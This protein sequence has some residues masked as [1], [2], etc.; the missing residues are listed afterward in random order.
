MADTIDEQIRRAMEDGQFDN[1]PGKGRPINLDENPFEDPEWRMAH[2]L[3]QEGGF[4]LPWIEARREIDS[5]LE[6]ARQR[7][8]QAWAK[9]R[10]SLAHGVD[11]HRIDLE[12]KAAQQQFIQKLESINKLI[13]DYNLQAPLLQVQMLMLKPEQEI[14]KVIGR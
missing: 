4:S 14:E 8:S 9:Q 5:E 12:W 7:L 3:L 6:S 1:L 10:A 13:R 11:L 2:H